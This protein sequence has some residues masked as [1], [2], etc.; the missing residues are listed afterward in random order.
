M[1]G[2]RG[3]YLYPK[4]WET[5]IPA[6]SAFIFLTFGCLYGTELRVQRL[7]EKS[8][9]CKID[10]I[11]AGMAQLVAQLI[12]QSGRMVLPKGRTRGPLDRL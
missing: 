6:E 11:Y 5:V 4:L 12:C 8:S 10:A 7:V 9:C 2:F 1:G 3:E